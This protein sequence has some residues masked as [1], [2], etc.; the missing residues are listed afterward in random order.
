MELVV[1]PGDR[2]EVG[3][4]ASRLLVHP[5]GQPAER[6]EVGQAGGRGEAAPPRLELR[7]QAEDLVQVADPPVLDLHAAVGLVPDQPFRG[8]ASQGLAH[9]R[10]A[11]PDDGGEVALAQPLPTGALAAEDLPPDRRVGD[12]GGLAGV[13]ARVLGHGREP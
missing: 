3:R 9:R 6:V 2:V 5:V 11:H 8:E 12:L 10:T 7:A 1:Q 13:R 4:V